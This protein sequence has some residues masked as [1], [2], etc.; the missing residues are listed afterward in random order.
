[1]SFRPLTYKKIYV[2][3]KY[4]T[5]DSKSPSSFQIELR[6]NFEI[7][8]GTIAQIHEV[9][10]PNTWYAISSNSNNLYFR[11][12]VLPPA[13]PQGITYTRIVIP[14]GNYTAP[15]LA[16]EIA[17]QL[18]AVFDVVGVNRTNTYSGSYNNLTNKI[19]ISS[20][21][22]EVI[23][24]P[25]TDADVPDFV[26]SFSNS[27]DLNNL[28]SINEVLSFTQTVSDS[29]T[30]TSPWITRFV[31]LLTALSRSISIY[32]YIMSRAVQQ[33]VHS[34]STFTNAIVKTIPVNAPFAGIVA[35]SYGV[36]DYDYINVSRRSIRRLTFRTTDESG[37]F[38]NLNGA[39]ASFSILFHN[40]DMV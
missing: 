24:I 10:I 4:R 27:V 32:I 20:N 23:F 22:T 16:T 3:S 7:P 12:Q 9:A 18:N 25:L 30:S 38:T 34:P 29:F 15:D 31:I 13:T 17:T 36:S 14:E 33:Q 19:T 11:H 6:E 21:Y 1:M 8:D 5:S 40:T 26:G 2:N 28:N 39:T 37:N 35:D